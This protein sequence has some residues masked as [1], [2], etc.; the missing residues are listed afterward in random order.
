M[1]ASW[2]GAPVSVGSMAVAFSKRAAA[3]AS[4]CGSHARELEGGVGERGVDGDRLLETAG[5][6][7]VLMA[8]LVNQAKLVLRLAVVG[9]DGGGFEHAPEALPAAQSRAQAGKFAA[10]IIPGEEEEEGR[11][12]QSF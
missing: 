9:I 7:G 6:L 12:R 4:W 11:S 2:K 1:R 10:Q 3:S 8:L 5:G